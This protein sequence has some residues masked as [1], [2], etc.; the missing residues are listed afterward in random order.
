MTK[1]NIDSKCIC[2]SEKLYRYCC[3]LIIYDDCK[4]CG[5]FIKYDTCYRCESLKQFL[6]KNK[7]SMLHKK[8]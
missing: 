4:K 3:S 5:S 1:I 2:G 6:S 7:K 8:I